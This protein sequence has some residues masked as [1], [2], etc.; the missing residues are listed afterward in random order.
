MVTSVPLPSTGADQPAVQRRAVLRRRIRL[1]VATT[2]GYNIIEAVV[3]AIA[4]G[5]IASSA[6]LIGFGLDSLVEVTSAAAVAWQFTAAEPQ[7]REKVTCA[8][9][10]WDVTITSDRH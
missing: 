8:A 5:T 2:I 10:A 1:L 6:A 3:A 4:A 7:R 9:S